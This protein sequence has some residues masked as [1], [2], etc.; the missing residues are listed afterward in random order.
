MIEYNTLNI[1]EYINIL[2]SVQWK[3]LSLRLLEKSL[4]NVISVKYVIDNKMIGVEDQL[5][6]QDAGLITD[7]IVI[8]KYQGKGYGKLLIN[9]LL[10]YIKYKLYNGE[11][12]MIQLLLAPGKQTFYNMFGFKVKREV[13]EDEMYM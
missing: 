6:M 3:M 13:A 10:E 8:S 11:E 7:V 9:S 1:E 5:L 2:N 12:M 4:K